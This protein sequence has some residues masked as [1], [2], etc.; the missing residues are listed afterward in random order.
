MRTHF[1]Q[2]L[3]DARVVRCGDHFLLPKTPRTLDVAYGLLWQLSIP[4]A[5]VFIMLFSTERTVRLV[6]VSILQHLLPAGKGTS[7][8]LDQVMQMQTL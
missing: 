6:R 5:P 7:H 2:Q 1:L 3:P 4:A 8:Y